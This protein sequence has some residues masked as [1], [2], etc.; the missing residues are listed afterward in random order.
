M[1]TLYVRP[2]KRRFTRAHIDELKQTIEERAKR[3]RVFPQQP[4]ETQESENSHDA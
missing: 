2:V 4:C 1:M 3:S